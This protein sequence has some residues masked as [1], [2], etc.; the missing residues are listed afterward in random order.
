MNN[1]DAWGAVEY[2]YI[3]DTRYNQFIFRSMSIN[4]ALKHHGLSSLGALISAQIPSDLEELRV[5]QLYRNASGS[6][7]IRSHFRLQFQACQAHLE[8]Q[9][10]RRTTFSFEPALPPSEKTQSEM[11][12]GQFKMSVVGQSWALTSALIPLLTRGLQ[13]CLINGPT[14]F[15]W[16]QHF[17]ISEEVSFKVKQ[18][19]ACLFNGK[20]ILWPTDW[21]L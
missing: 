4:H 6:E 12:V 17:S 18:L 14:T 1:T 7:P 2:L 21:Q 15:H 8:H 5:L 13:V 3:P 19:S 20:L 9:C 10:H 11:C 16:R